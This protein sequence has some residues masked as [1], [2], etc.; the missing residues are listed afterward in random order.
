MGGVRV[1]G[2]FPQKFHER[3]RAFL[4]FCDNELKYESARYRL[5]YDGAIVSSVVTPNN[6]WLLHG[7]GAI[8]YVLIAQ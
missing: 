3:L 7:D 6:S 4:D 2:Q 1:S 8:V 5:H